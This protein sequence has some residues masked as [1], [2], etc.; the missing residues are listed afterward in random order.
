MTPTG[1][2]FESMVIS[3]KERAD[4]VVELDDTTRPLL[5][6]VLKA[7]QAKADTAAAQTD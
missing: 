3:S 5:A 7:E 2:S 6:N 4:T 1:G